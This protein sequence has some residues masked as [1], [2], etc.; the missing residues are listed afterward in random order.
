MEEKIG[1]PRTSPAPLLGWLIAPLAVLLALAAIKVVGIN[2]DLTLDNMKPM[3][4]VVIAAILGTVPR[5]LKNNDMVPFTSA[6]LSLATLGVAMI[7]YQAIVSLTDL[8]AFTALQFLI[9]TFTVYF[10]DSRGRY[11]WATVTIFSFVGINIGMIAANFYNGELPTIFQQSNDSLVS[12]LNLQRQALGYIFFSYLMIF[13]L[14][15]LLIAVLSRGL[16]NPESDEGWF[17]KISS[18]QDTWNKS[19]LPLQI[20][21]I[22][23]ILAHAASLW[24]FD[25]VSVAD[26]LGV[27]NVEGYHGHFGF[28]AAF[29]TGIIAMLVAGMVAERW[30][31]RA[32]FIGSMWALYQVSSWYEKGM[33]QASQLDGTWGALIWLGFTFFICVGIYMISTHEKWGGWSNKEDHEI[34]G[35][36]K[37]WNAHWASIMIGMAFFFGLVIRVQ[38]YFVPSMNAY[39]TGNWDMTGGSD[40]WY[41]KRVV[42]Y[43]LANE[44]HLIIDADRSYPLGGVNPRPPLFTWSIAIVSML[45]EPMLGDDAVWYAML[46]LPAVYGALTIF[47]IATIAKD[48][49]GKST[50]VIAAWL[51]AFMPAHVSHSTWA[52]AD[53]DAFV[54]LFISLGFM[55]WMK[56]VKYSG[57]ERLTKTSS[58]GLFSIFSSYGVVARERKAAMAYAMLAG[59]SFGVASLGWKGFV[60]GP[61]IL[62]LAYFVQVALNMFRR[63]DS[64]TLNALFLTM[65]GINLIMALPFY[66]H[67]Q[68]DLIFDGTGLQ[69]FLFVLGFTLVIAYVTTGFRDKPWLLVLGTLAVSATIFFIILWTLKQ[70][71]ISNAWDVLFTGSGYFTKTKIFGTVAEANAPDRG[72]LFAQ[73]SPI[74]LVLALSMGFY[75]LWSALRNRNQSHLVFGI[76]IFTATYM[77]WTA[78][79]FMFNATPAVAVLGAWGITSLWKRANWA[80]LMKTWKKFGI[81]TPADRI[82]GARKAV[83]RTPSFSAILLIM[84]LLGGQQFTYGLDA[85]IP[86]SVDAEDELDETIFNMIPDA[87]RWELAGFSLL[88]SSAYS[89]NSYLGSFGSGF[90][91]QGWNSAYKWF[92]N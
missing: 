75:S 43:I 44:A 31:T 74:V 88:D 64:T 48:H 38:W 84:V 9:L 28:W 32:M 54:M 61:S 14:L 46:G 72:Q 34:S 70:L 82:T 39:G 92:V 10:F 65:L 47:P 71:D 52:L 89:G 19:T 87:L 36:R 42:D 22:V 17:S 56:A 25:S 45:L 85:A 6:T 5:L 63:R 1:S 7:G 73:L 30:H 50:G 58:P 2:F 33:W 26:K 11:E 76:W 67:P 60:V 49:F 66:G 27:T 41:M 21:I 8:G 15:G 90:N 53:H 78:A 51:I 20:A 57:S 24:H 83:W 55:Y 16:L 4:V 13:I 77:A 37:F 91:Q 69:P 23:W 3:I 79:R 68:L 80:G 40:P 81:R 29:F 86:S 62:F 59:V 12:T 35:A 18:S